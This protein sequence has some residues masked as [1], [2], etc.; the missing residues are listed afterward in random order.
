MGT[1]KD[2]EDMRDKNR[3]NY[4][5]EADIDDDGN[6]PGMGSITVQSSI[7]DS[8]QLLKRPELYPNNPY[9]EEFEEDFKV[10]QNIKK[11]REKERREQ[12]MNNTREKETMPLNKNK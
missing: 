8:K 9:Y 11:H 4:H 7:N 2:F 10:S 12:Q 5:D 3:R 1:I 6:Q